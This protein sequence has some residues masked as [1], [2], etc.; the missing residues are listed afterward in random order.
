M[1]ECQLPQICVERTLAIIKP[2]AIDQEDEI[3]EIIMRHGFTITQKRKVRLSPE[4]ATEFFATQ[5]GQPNFP[6]LVQYMSSG[7][8]TVFVLAKV[9]AVADW[10][11]IVEY[12]PQDEKQKGCVEK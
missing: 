6:T 11:D 9:N 12:S 5:V 7:R 10:K 4:Q 1:E 8:I 3:E 2:D